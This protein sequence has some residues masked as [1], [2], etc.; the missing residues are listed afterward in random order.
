M[1]L[2][3][4]CNISFNLTKFS[5]LKSELNISELI[6]LNTMT[7]PLKTVQ[8]CFLKRIFGISYNFFLCILVCNVIHATL[9]KL[10]NFENS[11]GS[12][13]NLFICRSRFERRKKKETVKP[14]EDPL[15][16]SIHF[17]NGTQKLKYGIALGL[18]F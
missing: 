3:A 14:I 18:N 9:M 5:I 12:L 13:Q 7:L 4:I 2:N 17:Y 15:K 11:Q 8:K 16:F 1:Y 6:C 10:M